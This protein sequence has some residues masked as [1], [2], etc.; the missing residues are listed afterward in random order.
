MKTPKSAYSAAIKTGKVEKHIMVVWVDNEAGVLARVVGLF[1]GRGYNIESLAVAEI[2]KKQKLSRITLVTSGSPE[3]ISQIKKQLE[4]L[5][6]VHKVADFMRNDP[7]I[8]FRDMALLKVV[9]NEKK[10]KQSKETM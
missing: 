10:K 7:R 4:K 6:P 8:I 5:V 9:S 2:D 3:V 1:S